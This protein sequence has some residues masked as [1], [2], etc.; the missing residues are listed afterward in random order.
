MRFLLLSFIVACTQ[1]RP[2]EL[3]SP[4]EVELI[5]PNDGDVQED[6]QG[7]FVVIVRGGVPNIPRLPGIGNFFNSVP[8]FSDF[9]FQNGARIPSVLD[10]GLGDIFG[11][12]GTTEETD[13][14]SVCGPLCQMFRVLQGIQG[15]IDDIHTQIDGNEPNFFNHTFFGGDFDINNSTYEE[16]ELEDGTKVKINRTVIADSDGDGNQF[17]FHSSVFHNF[18]D[19]TIEADEIPV[20]VEDEPAVVTEDAD[21]TE[22]DAETFD[23]IPNSDPTINEINDNVQSEEFPLDK[24]AIDEGLQQ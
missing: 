21:S 14:D 6:G 5:N 3:A 4:D 9:P 7:P 1:A 19:D 11:D 15:E 10:G 24:F 18:G 13:V 8:G 16:K 23:V 20:I 22:D 17:Y 2:Q 12:A